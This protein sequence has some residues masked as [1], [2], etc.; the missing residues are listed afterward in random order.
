M[1]EKSDSTPKKVSSSN[2]KNEI[3]KAYNELL[4][5]LKEAKSQDPQKEM[6]TKRREEILKEVSGQ[7]DEKIIQQIASLKVSL[8]GSL[9]S[10]ED[11]LNTS[12]K[13]LNKTQEAIKIQEDRLKELYQINAEAD[14]LAALIASQKEKKS[15]FE[16]YMAEEKARW[17]KEQKERE[18]QRKEE[19]EMLKKQRK[20]EEEE[21]NYKIQ[22]KRKIESDQYEEKKNKQEKELKEKKEA[23][24]QEIKSREQAVAESENE[25]QDLRK[26]VEEFPATL[27]K[28]VDNAI[29]IT[30]ENL[31][32]EYDYEKLLKAKEYE[33]ELKLH[34][35]TITNLQNRI[36]D[37]ELQLKQAYS[38]IDSAE[39]NV[40]DITIKAI[41]SSA[42]SRNNE[43]RKAYQEP[44]RGK[45]QE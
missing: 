19:E 21:Y 30:T 5:Q 29:K 18:E 12:F 25:L 42:S 6:E 44:S 39:N 24:E 43:Q 27:Q 17:D 8:N 1:P 37:L 38:K 23:F 3:L 13:K 41:E 15:E 9:D 14:S 11:Q 40:K 35:Q 36:K 26:Q 16:N 2:T 32:K 34:T 33:S 20:R 45:E 7:S 22:Q 10:I 31:K 28:E 4:D